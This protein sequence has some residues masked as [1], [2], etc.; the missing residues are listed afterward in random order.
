MG[1]SVLVAAA[2]AFH[3]QFIH[4]QSVQLI[5]FIPVVIIALGY[6]MAVIPTKDGAAR[7]RDVPYL[8]VF[9]IVG[10]VT[11]VTTL[12][13]LLYTTNYGHFGSA[14]LTLIVLGRA[15]FLFAITL[16]F[17]IRDLNFDKQ[18]NLKTIPGKFGVDKTRFISVSLISVFIITECARYIFYSGQLTVFLALLVSGIIAAG[19]ILKA[20]PSGSEY[21]YS[22]GLEGTM[23]IQT[24]LVYTA[25]NLS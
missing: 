7:L 9:L 12:L 19:F 22:L 5:W 8:K 10:V 6:T 18:T 2:L 15:L 11:Y 14:N 3:A 17:D 4:N 21:F 13:P 23:I 16:P 1:L 24:F 20:R 25:M